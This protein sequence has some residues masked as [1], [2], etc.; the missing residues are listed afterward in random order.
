MRSDQVKKGIMRAASRSLLKAVGLSDEDI[1]QPW[2]A[3]VNSWNELVPG[4]VHLR[5]IAEAV[6]EVG[7]AGAG[8]VMLKGAPV[9]QVANGAVPDKVP[10]GLPAIELV[11]VVPDPSFNPHLPNKPVPEVSSELMLV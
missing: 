3:V 6:K 1:S 8:N 2:I 11:A 7:A 5:E 9:T 4:H 10:A